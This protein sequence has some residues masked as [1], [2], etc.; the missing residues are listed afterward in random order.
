MTTLAFTSHDSDITA[1]N[2]WESLLHYLQ[3]PLTAPAPLD[4]TSSADRHEH[5]QQRMDYLSGG[6]VLRTSTVAEGKLLLTRAFQENRSRN[7]GHAG[8]MLSGDSALGKTTTAKRLM[9]WVLEEYTKQVPHWEQDEHIPVMYVEVPSGSNAKD[10]LREF[11][12]F[13]G[14]SVLSRDTTADLR[15]KV[16]GAIRRARTQ[17][18]VVDEL[19]NLAGRASGLGEAVDLLKGLHNDVSATFLY[20]GLDVTTSTLMHG[21]RGRQLMNRFAVVELETYKWSNADH[22]KEWKNLIRGFEAE[23]QLRHHPVKTLDPLAEY[24]YERT[25]GS[26]GSLGRLLTG[27][28]IDLIQNKAKVELL[29]KKL[30]D[31]YTLDLTAETFY[32]NVLAKKKTKSMSAL[33]K[34]M[35]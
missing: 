21:P 34:V 12:D 17:L 13:Y 25:R 4:S 2:R 24:L 14:L 22:R 18:I 23:L 20:C 29:D 15:T 33:E 10:L 9:R 16:V 35:A 1:L 32:R 7:S 26:I 8:V 6:I 30:L 27:T 19:H 28:A 11:C 3:H 31:A 5:D